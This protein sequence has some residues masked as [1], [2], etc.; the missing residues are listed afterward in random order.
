MDGMDGFIFVSH[1]I[2][3]F[4]PP[5]LAPLAMRKSSFPTDFSRKRIALVG[6]KECGGI[7]EWIVVRISFEH[8]MVISPANTSHA[9]KPLTGHRNQ[10]CGHV[11]GIQHGGKTVTPCCTAIGVEI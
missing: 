9:C 8:G 2:T 1:V 10:K 7:P 4:V 11:C 3:H 5:P 6:F